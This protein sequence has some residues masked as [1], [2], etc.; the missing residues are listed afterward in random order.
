MARNTK[1]SGGVVNVLSRLQQAL[2]EGGSR[3]G[4][5]AAVSPARLWA[6]WKRAPSCSLLGPRSGTVAGAWGKGVV[7]K[8]AELK[9]QGKEA[10]ADSPG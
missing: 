1:P 8:A 9:V 5:P 4:A 2:K 7:R 3:A 10:A 6:S